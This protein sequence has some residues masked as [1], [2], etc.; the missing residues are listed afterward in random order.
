M[1]LG[2]VWKSRRLNTSTIVPGSS[3]VGL[4]RV[5]AGTTVPSPGPSSAAP[6]SKSIR[7]A[8]P[9]DEPTFVA[10]GMAMG[11]K[12][13]CDDGDSHAISA[14]EIRHVEVGPRREWRKKPFDV[15]A[16]QLTHQTRLQIRL[17]GTVRGMP[18]ASRSVGRPDPSGGSSRPPGPALRYSGRR[19]D[20][21]CSSVASSRMRVAFEP[22]SQSRS[23]VTPP[24]QRIPSRPASPGPG[25]PGQ[26]RDEA[27]AR[28]AEHLEN[29]SCDAA[30]RVDVHRRG[31]AM[32]PE[33]RHALAP[34]VVD[35]GQKVVPQAMSGNHLDAFERLVTLAESSEDRREMC[36]RPAGLRLEVAVESVERGPT[37]SGNEWAA[38]VRVDLVPGEEWVEVG[39][40]AMVRLVLETGPHPLAQR[41]ASIDLIRR[42]SAEERRPMGRLVVLSD[43]RISCDQIRQ[44]FSR[45]RHVHRR[46]DG[47][48][49]PICR[50]EASSRARARGR[51]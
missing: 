15:E 36:Q 29:C 44:D 50:S 16:R 10:I 5:P 48:H 8:A 22:K 28:V 41:A 17:T 2:M 25:Q 46:V 26:D 3:A 47:H 1:V 39:M 23:T 43:R 37:G 4:W 24:L 7:I 18:G 14:V 38:F 31:R 9:I 30:V 33:H 27:E 13:V 11:R 12:R 19:S 32:A 51:T 34:P 20:T 49:R 42:Q 21:V 35:D 45:D 6:S 40:M